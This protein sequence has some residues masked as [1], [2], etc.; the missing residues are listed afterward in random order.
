MS[1]AATADDAGLLAVARVRRVRETDSRI[2]LQ[3]ALAEQRAAQK[4]VDD[5]RRRLHDADRF[6]AGSAADFVA[7]RG[8]LQVLG[9]VLLAAVEELD[10]TRTISAAALEAW[11]RDRA[12]LAAIEGLLERRLAARRTEAARG[13]ARELD[14]LA[15]QRW[16]RRTGEVA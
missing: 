8:S 3:T 16:L 9:M 15:T 1:S 5:L 13:E 7:L 11:Q 12:K 6:A 14:D 4:R 2:G 10:Q